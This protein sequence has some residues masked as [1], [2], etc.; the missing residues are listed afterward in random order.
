[1]TKSCHTK[2]VVAEV[3]TR[4]P[5]GLH[6][7]TGRGVDQQYVILHD[8]YSN[9]FTNIG[10]FLQHA[11]QST[12]PSRALLTGDAPP[13]LTGNAC[14]SKTLTVYYSMG[15]DLSS[16]SVEFVFCQAHLGYAKN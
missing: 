5:P 13:T 8:Q 15:V 4:R 6:Q 11:G 7:A 9:I 2:T 16:G 10:L 14:W 3:Q 12:S 1:M